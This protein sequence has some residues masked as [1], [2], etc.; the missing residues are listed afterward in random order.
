M[1]MS[2]FCSSKCC[3]NIKYPF[4]SSLPQ[5]E[6]C[7]PISVTSIARCLTF[8]HLTSVPRQMQMS[9]CCSSKCWRNIKWPFQGSLPLLF[10][11]KPSLPPLGLERGY[12]INSN[13]Q[14]HLEL[15][16]THPCLIRFQSLMLLVK[17][18]CRRNNYDPIRY[19]PKS[20]LSIQDGLNFP[21]VIVIVVLGFIQIWYVMGGWLVNT[22]EFSTKMVSTLDF[23]RLQS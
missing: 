2:T 10:T 1:Q 6:M 7:R 19:Q 5:K 14:E 18:N 9:T 17:L 20:A 12:R 23:R 22:N 21:A 8:F 13:F 11:K 16:I 4:H 15:P 3:R